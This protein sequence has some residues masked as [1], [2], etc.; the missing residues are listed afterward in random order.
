MAVMVRKAP[1]LGEIESG[2]AARSAG[3]PLFTF[4]E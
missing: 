2:R 3:T 4:I 1:L